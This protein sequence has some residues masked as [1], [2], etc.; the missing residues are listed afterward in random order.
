MVPLENDGNV[1][2]SSRRMHIALVVL[3][4]TSDYS[5]FVEIGL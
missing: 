1:G 4:L 3:Y 5:Q 2:Y